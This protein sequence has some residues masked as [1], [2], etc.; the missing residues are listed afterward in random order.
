VSWD[1]R[2][3]F[4]ERLTGLVINLE[5]RKKGREK[6]DKRKKRNLSNARNWISTRGTPNIRWT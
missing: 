1:I 5:K 3:I 6:K 2:L 4:T